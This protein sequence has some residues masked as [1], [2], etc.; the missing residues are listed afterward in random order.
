VIIN[1]ITAIGLIIFAS[2]V[3]G[4]TVVPQAP[5][6]PAP[7]RPTRSNPAPHEDAPLKDT[8]DRYTQED[9][10]AD[11]VVTRF[12]DVKGRA[13]TVFIWITYKITSSDREAAQNDVFVMGG[14]FEESRKVN[15]ETHEIRLD[16]GSKITKYEVE[17][18]RN[19]KL[20]AKRD[21]LASYAWV[22]KPIQ[23]RGLKYHQ[24]AL[25]TGQKVSVDR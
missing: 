13:R 4:G 2:V 10:D 8:Y 22:A 3:L 12:T 16:A 17:Y 1:R 23:E 9:D 6:K 19:G 20:I 11:I 7:K 5:K 14:D 21:L 18:A 24:R 15:E 25:E